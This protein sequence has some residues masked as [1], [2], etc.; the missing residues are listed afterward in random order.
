MN[1]FFSFLLKGLIIFY[2][3]VISPFFLPRCR[4]IPTCSE[5]AISSINKYGAIKGSRLMLKRI[6]NCHPWGGSGHDPVP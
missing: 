2:Q 1:A 6:L 4:Y 3:K 5:Y